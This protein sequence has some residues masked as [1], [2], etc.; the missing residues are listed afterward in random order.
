MDGSKVT[1]GKRLGAGAFATVYHAQVQGSRSSW[2]VKRLDRSSQK[3]QSG[4][5]V[6]VLATA[7][8]H[9]NLVPFRGWYLDS[10]NILCLVLGHCEGGTLATVLKTRAGGAD[11][12]LFPEDMVLCWF[13]QLLLALHHLHTRHILHRDLKPENVLLSKNLRVVKLADFG[14]SKQLEAGVGLAV[15]CLGTPHYM[16]PEA[17]SHRPYTFASDM[18]ALGVLV[19]KILRNAYTPLPLSCSRQLQ[20]LVG[21]L[22][23][24]DPDDRPTTTELLGLGIVRKHLQL[25]LALAQSTPRPLVPAGLPAP[26]SSAGLSTNAGTAAGADSGSDSR[27]GSSTTMT[28]VSGEADGDCYDGHQADAVR[29]TGAASQQHMA[30]AGRAHAAGQEVSSED[31]ASAAEDGAVRSWDHT[32]QWEAQQQQQA[33]N[34]YQAKV[35][36]QRMARQQVG[37]SSRVWVVLLTAGTTWVHLALQ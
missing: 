12:G 13:V 4:N 37:R 27:R 22:L 35:L 20:Q 21:M 7:G 14:V 6:E 28:G 31:G 19:V 23:R 24:A 5:E 8:V 36:E 34:R 29:A 15:T 26:S 3:Q 33:L 16:S 30:A 11:E 9:P 17:L 2:V 32:A 1:L 10:S 18:W 25:L